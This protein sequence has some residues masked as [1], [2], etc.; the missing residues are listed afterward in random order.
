MDPVSGGE[1]IKT[2]IFCFKWSA[3]PTVNAYISLWSSSQSLF[4]P[5]NIFYEIAHFSVTIILSAALRSFYKTLR[6]L[7]MMK[8]PPW[9]WSEDLKVL[10]KIH[11][12]HQVSLFWNEC[13]CQ[14][15]PEDICYHHSHLMLMS[16]QTKW[17][18]E[19]CGDVFFFL[20]FQP[21]YLQMYVCATHGE[22]C[23]T[24]LK[25]K[26]KPFLQQCDI[27]EHAGN[28]II[29]QER[30][31]QRTST[32]FL[33]RVNHSSIFPLLSSYVF[34]FSFL[35]LPPFVLYPVSEDVIAAFSQI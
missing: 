20:F 14:T 34:T 24:A 21:Y 16:R 17:H 29:L 35:L 27:Q 6:L 13:I 8:R 19:G 12:H 1:S 25:I 18:P 31:M 4:I 33:T 9:T 7:L 3:A 22:L 30:K 28:H 2:L 15:F 26:A 32:G 23:L 5:L 11:F 10:Y